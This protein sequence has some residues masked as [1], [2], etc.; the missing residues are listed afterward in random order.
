M[1]LYF[2][3]KTTLGRWSV[4]LITGMPILFFTGSLL[5]PL[6]YESVPA[7]RTILED[8]TVRPGLALTMLTGMAFGISAFATGL[9]S[10]IKRGERALL[11]YISTI[12]G[13]LLILFL[14]G[15]IFFP[16]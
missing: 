14:L 8:I 10:I 4:G 6:L 16:H 7:G 13:G 1:K 12:T 11:T 5:R 9:V 3:P 2:I 15:E